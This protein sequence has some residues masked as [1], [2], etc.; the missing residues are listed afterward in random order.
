MLK[1]KNLQVATVAVE[2]KDNGFG[3]EYRLPSFLI[4][5][6]LKTL[7]SY[8]DTKYA[9]FYAR[10]VPNLKRERIIGVRIPRLR[11]IAKEYQKNSNGIDFLQRL[12]HFYYEENTVYAFIIAQESDFDKCIEMTEK[13]LPHID[14][15]ATCDSFRPKVF[16]KNKAKL[17]PY[18]HKWIKSD[19][20]YTVRFAV[21]TL[22]VHYLND[23]FDE[24]YLDL[25]ASVK[26]EEYYIRMMQAW[27]F[28]TALTVRYEQT[29]KVLT[30][31]KLSV[32]VHDKTIQ[33]AMESR[34]VS[35]Q[36][37][38]ILKTMK[39]KS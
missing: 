7:F 26:R 38:A 15:W 14:N 21:E 20:E 28:A 8:Q 4:M 29:I 3:R 23:D 33:K 17:L 9:D 39:R 25:V 5:D 37:K 34:R 36:T 6:L 10:L 12:P 13:F 1:L 19:E 11:K 22:M 27:Y 24:E 31:N 30:S 16:A 2:F 32:W 18:I 35:P